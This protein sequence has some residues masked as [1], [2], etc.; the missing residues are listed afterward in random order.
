MIK[1]L[2]TGSAGFIG[3]SLSKKRENGHELIGIDNIN[4]YYDISLKER[5]DIL[6]RMRNLN[7]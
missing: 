4:N 6:G 3:A 2:V 1:I 5:L 7:L